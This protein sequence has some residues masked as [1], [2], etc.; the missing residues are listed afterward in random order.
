MLPIVYSGLVAFGE[1]II[2]VMV[3]R[4]SRIIRIYKWHIIT[5]AAILAI[6]VVVFGAFLLPDTSKIRILFMLILWVCSFLVGVTFMWIFVRGAVSLWLE[7]WL[8]RPLRRWEGIAIILL[9]VALFLAF[10]HSGLE[11]GAAQ[12]AD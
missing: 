11:L 1:G 3:M 4:L 7:P 10:A 2:D 9:A 6:Y 5:F 12:D 8:R